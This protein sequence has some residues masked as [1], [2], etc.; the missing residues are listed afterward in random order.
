MSA[1]ILSFSPTIYDSGA[2]IWF[3]PATMY[4]IGAGII[5]AELLKYIDITSIK[6]KIVFFIICIISIIDIISK[7]Y[8]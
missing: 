1:F 7:V 4:V 3:I 5:F 6:F 8:M 2:R